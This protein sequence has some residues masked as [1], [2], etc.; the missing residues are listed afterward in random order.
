MANAPVV[1]ANSSP[2]GATGCMQYHHVPSP[3]PSGKAAIL[4]PELVEAI[5][6][7]RQ[8]VALTA[9]RLTEQV[10]G[11]PP[12]VIVLLTRAAVL[13]TPVPDAAGSRRR[14]S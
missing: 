6:Q 3:A 1:A 7:G 2:L 5:L 8:P 13:L 10:H 9:T 11:Y 12:M 4:S 14:L